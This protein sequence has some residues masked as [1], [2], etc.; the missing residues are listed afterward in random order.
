MSFFFCV[1]TTSFIT[2]VTKKKIYI[3][4]IFVNSLMHDFIY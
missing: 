4:V 1:L 2:N 3:Q